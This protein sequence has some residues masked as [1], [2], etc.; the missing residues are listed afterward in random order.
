MLFWRNRFN[1]YLLAG[2]WLLTGCQSGVVGGKNP[3]TLR[4]HHVINPDGTPRCLAIKFL[5]ASPMELH[6]DRSPF[7]HEGYV[8]KAAVL[9]HLGTY[10]IQVEF[11]HQGTMLLDSVSVANRGQRI[12]IYSDFGDSRWL[13]APVLNRRITNGVFQFTPDASREEAQRVVDG[14]N[15]VAAKWQKRK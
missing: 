8:K 11:D 6:I 13:A 9:D 15:R 14:L 5:R 1:I 3:S 12:A 4:F 10:E 7:L 2:M